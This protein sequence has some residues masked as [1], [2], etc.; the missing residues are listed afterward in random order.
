M[1]KRFAISLVLLLYVR[2]ETH[3][4]PWDNPPLNRIFSSESILYS[5]CRVILDLDP[6]LIYIRSLERLSV[7]EPR[8]DQINI[9]QRNLERNSTHT[10]ALL[11][12]NTNSL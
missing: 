11:H 6:S 5:F 1:R 7:T 12:L 10:S 3:N 4:W 9:L 8:N 2:G